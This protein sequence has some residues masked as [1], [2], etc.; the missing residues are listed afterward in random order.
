MG[1]NRRRRSLSRAAVLSLCVLAAAFCQGADKPL[2]VYSADVRARVVGKLREVLSNGNR[3]DRLEG[4]VTFSGGGRFFIQ[5]GEDGLKIRTAAGRLPKPGERVA[6]VGTPSLEGGRVVFSA[7]SW[8]VLGRGE[9]PEPRPVSAEELV[10]AEVGLDGRRIAVRGRAIGLTESGFA[11]NVGGIPINIAADELPDFLGDCERTSPE[12]DVVGVVEQ[13]LDSSALLGDEQTVMG[14]KVDVAS[15][16]D[17]VLRTDLAYLAA[18]RDATFVIAFAALLSVLTIGLV[19]FLVV[20]FRQRRGLFRTRTIMAE[21]K[22]MADDI[23]DTIEQHLVGAGMLLKI[24]RIDE[25]QG[26]LVRAKREIRDIVWGLKNDDMM[27]LSP[28]EM[29]RNLAHDENTK[30]IYRVATRLEGLPPRLDAAAMRDLSLIVRETIGN[31]VK[32]GGAKHIAISSEAVGK[33]GW[34]MCLS[35]DGTPFDPQTAP[36]AKEGHFGIAGMKQRALRLGAT[37]DIE[38]RG[39][40]MVVILRSA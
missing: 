11:M 33:D 5:S 7:R 8:E 34:M 25:V 13:L 40:G 4:T 2:A 35:N 14:V 9:V 1:G 23:H 3:V 20:I 19:A 28:A 26:V 12:V 30:G 37:L 18:R 15:P 22:R 21:R 6:V 10:D 36:G 32:H 38:H 29:I 16:R 27:R 39:K 31:A 17:I 24:G